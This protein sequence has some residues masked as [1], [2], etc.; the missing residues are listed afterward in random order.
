MFNVAS[1]KFS[2][3]KISFKYN[4]CFLPR[5]FSSIDM[6]KHKPVLVLW[7]TTLFSAIFIQREQ[8]LVIY[9]Y[10]CV[11][12]YEFIQQQLPYNTITTTNRTFAIS[13]MYNSTNN[14]NF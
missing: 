6:F 10:V 1:L 3:C 8:K 11:S 7:D 4:I 13:I 5:K 9:I 12:V 2:K 14:E